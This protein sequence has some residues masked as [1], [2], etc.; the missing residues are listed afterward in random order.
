MPRLPRVSERPTALKVVSGLWFGLGVWKLLAT[1]LSFIH[2][3]GLQIAMAD[4]SPA[5][6]FGAGIMPWMLAGG[7][8]LTLVQ[9]GI[10][11]LITVS[12]YYLW[13]LRPWAR[14]SLEIVSWVSLVVVA[15]FGAFWMYV[16]LEA[17]SHA[18]RSM[19]AQ[20][21]WM[22]W[23]ALALFTGVSIALG[24]SI[25][26]LRG[27]SIRAAVRPAAGEI[28]EGLGDEARKYQ[29]PALPSSH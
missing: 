9:W 20:F 21:D 17:T 22:G 3:I 19:R 29:S 1:S 12:A 13:K 15:G 10:A 16:F 4:S 7:W 14:L 8:V 27:R 26:L 6:G 18:P 25:G 24:V 11:A 28:D 2:L 23:L 5:M